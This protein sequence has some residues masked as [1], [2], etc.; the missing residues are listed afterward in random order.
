M[1]FL[2]FITKKI[3]LFIFS[4]FLSF[5]F[6][7]TSYAIDITIWDLSGRNG[8]DEFYDNL[9]KEYKK[10]NPDVRIL[11]SDYLGKDFTGK[12]LDIPIYYHKRDHDYS[13][14]NLKKNIHQSFL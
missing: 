12:D 1:N 9:N 6:I 4:F 2:K 11:G 5:G 3:Y 10:I 7:T 8:Q 13:S 14:S